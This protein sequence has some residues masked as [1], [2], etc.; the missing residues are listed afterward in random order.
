MK[1][2]GR[3]SFIFIILVFMAGCYTQTP[4]PA[5]YE[6]S[7]QQKMQS[8]G[9]WN[10]L[11]ED[12]AAQIRETLRKWGYLSQPV[13]IQPACGAPIGPCEPHYETPFGEGFYDLLLTQLVNYGLKVSTQENGAL[14]VTN[15]V[16]VLWHDEDRI[17]RAGWPGMITAAAALAGGWGWVIRDAQIHGLGRRESAALAGAGITAAALYDAASGMFT[18]GGVPHSEVIITTSIKDY[19]RYLMRKTDVYYINDKDYWHYKTPPPPE[20]IEITGS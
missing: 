5:T 3:L 9:H 20:M 8:A 4:K 16:Q 15:K 12:V 1:M 14:V 18:K 6:F 10:V 19:D 7:L 13:Y 2:L 17:A 11:A